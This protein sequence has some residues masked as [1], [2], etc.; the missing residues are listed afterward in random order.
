[1]AMHYWPDC[2]HTYFARAHRD[3]LLV[4]V[5]DWMTRLPTRLGERP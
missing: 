1:V 5:E 4:A 2:D 3:R